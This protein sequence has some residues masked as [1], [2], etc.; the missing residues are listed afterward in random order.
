MS[1]SKDSHNDHTLTSLVIISGRDCKPELPLRAQHPD[2]WVK[3]GAI[4]EKTLCVLGNISVDGL[5]LGNLCGDVYTDRIVAK[6]LQDPIDVIGE[7]VIDPDF[8]L[9]ATIRTNCIS[10]FTGAGVEPIKIK[11]DLDL[12]GNDIG[13]VGNIS[14]VTVIAP[15]IECVEKISGKGDLT[16][17]NDGDLILQ[18]TGDV[19]LSNLAM[20]FDLTKSILSNVRAVVAAPGCPLELITDDGFKVKIAGGDGIDMCARDLCNLGNITSFGPKITIQDEVCINGNL[21]VNGQSEINGDIDMTKGNIDNVGGMT[22]AAACDLVISTDAG[23]KL[24]IGGSGDGIDMC[25]KDLCNVDTITSQGPK[26]TL[27]NDL[28]VNGNAT[29]NGDTIIDGDLDMMCRE[30]G[31]IETIRANLWLGKNSPFYVG[32]LMNMIPGVVTDVAIDMHERQIVSANNISSARFN[33]ALFDDD[34][35][36]VDGQL[37]T[38][39][40]GVWKPLIP[41]GGGGLVTSVTGGTGISASPSTG[42]VTV[43]NDG[44][45]SVGASGVGITILGTAANPTVRN[46]GILSVTGG[47]AISVTGPAQNPTVNNTGVI[48]ATGGTG[49]SVDMSTGSVTW[50]NDGVLSVTG[51]TGISSSGGQNPDI[52]N[53]GVLTVVAGTGISS[54]GGQNPSIAN[55][56]VLSA[57]GGTGISVSASTGAITWTNTSPA[58]SVSLTH[59]G[60]SFNL[61]NASPQSGPALAVKGLNMGTGITLSQNTAQ[62]TITNNSPATSV[63]LTSGGGSFAMVNGSPQSGPAL[64]VKGLGAGTGIS[65]V[66]GGTAVTV[67]NSG[68]LSVGAGV[69]ISS[70]GGQNPTITNTSP[71]SSV[72]LGSSG[73]THTLV[74]DSSGPTLAVKGFTA[75]TNVTIDNLGTA[76]RINAA[77]SS[78]ALVGATSRWFHWAFNSTAGNPGPIGSNITVVAFSSAIN[79]S[80]R[81]IGGVVLFQFRQAAINFSGRVEY[82]LRGLESSIWVLGSSSSTVQVNGIPGTAGTAVPLQIPTPNWVQEIHWGVYMPSDLNVQ[83]DIKVQLEFFAGVGYVLR[84]TKTVGTTLNTLTAMNCHG[85][86]IVYS[87]A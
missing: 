86:D 61:V 59:G 35:N 19:I 32:D 72:T 2:L 13:N 87:A 7:L 43:T 14:A 5:I 68:V 52:T 57:T 60:G 15:F 42:A 46:D 64:T 3:G 69:G 26:I 50:T 39:V 37:M 56:G 85:G 16:I 83:R 10:D 47:T 11:S 53:D 70:T 21:T 8:D 65:M 12:C 9:V 18:P 80:Y 6:E 81:Q 62:I 51:G 41:G 23:T 1:A 38:L 67:T 54:S 84:A 24:K 27:D 4:I 44:V 66:S 36:G 33:L 22:G 34:L 78:P 29:I 79:A 20:D 45:L 82:D 71:A 30:L 49:I 17:C 63:T 75:G 31:N 77:V 55:T 48:M 28:C 76:L 58:T 25:G 74:T 40:G 73:G